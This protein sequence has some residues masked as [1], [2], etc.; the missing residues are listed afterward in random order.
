MR[1]FFMFKCKICNAEFD[2]YQM[3]RRHCSRKHKIHSSQ[4][5]IDYLLNG[6]HPVCKCGCGGKTKWHRKNAGDI[7]FNPYIFGHYSRVINNWGHNKKAQL[8]SAETRRIR[9]KEGKI[10][11]WCKGLTKDTDDRIKKLAEK[12][13]NTINSNPEELIKRSERMVKFRKDGT[14]PT[15]YRE[16]SSQWKG[17]VSSIQNI[18]RND[19]RLYEQWKYP[20]LVRDGFKCV[21]CQHT[22]DLHVHHNK[23]TFSEIIKKVMTNDDYENIDKFDVK[24]QVTDKVIDYHIKNSVSGVVLCSECHNKIHPSLNF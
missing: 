4:T 23:E 3:L 5:C 21:S 2:K 18:A 22:K 20:I 1:S 12:T 15:M 14:V 17:G 16:K 6:V 10:T 24:K 9:F 19:K 13:K 7:K 8:K 11:I